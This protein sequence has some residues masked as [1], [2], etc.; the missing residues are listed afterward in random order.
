MS[1]KVTSL[2]D[3][4]DWDEARCI[5][6]LARLERLKQQVRSNMTPISARHY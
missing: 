2:L 1:S 4:G 6:A 3:G 5:E